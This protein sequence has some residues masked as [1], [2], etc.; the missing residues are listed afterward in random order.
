MPPQQNRVTEDAKYTYSLLGNVFEKQIKKHRVK[1][2]EVLQSLASPGKKSQLMK[3]I[4]LRKSSK[5]CQ[6]I[7]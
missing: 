4:S 1:Q 3:K 5:Y 6:Y 2:V 7:N